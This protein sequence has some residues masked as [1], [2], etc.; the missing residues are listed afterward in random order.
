MSCSLLVYRNGYIA[1]FFLVAVHSKY[2]YCL[3][4]H[5]WWVMTR[6]EASHFLP[7]IVFHCALAFVR[8]PG[9]VVAVEIIM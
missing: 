5:G 4:P 8:Q 2:I 6:V 7:K 1:L 9:S 3:F